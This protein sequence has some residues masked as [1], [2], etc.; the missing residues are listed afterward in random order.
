MRAAGP[1]GEQ[2]E[3][4]SAQTGQPPD[5]PQTELGGAQE[6]GQGGGP[7]AVLQQDS[8][9]GLRGAL[10]GPPQDGADSQ[11]VRQGRSATGAPPAGVQHGSGGVAGL[12]DAGLL[13][14][15]GHG[16]AGAPEGPA[17]DGSSP[18]GGQAGQ[19]AAPRGC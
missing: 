1:A 14:R 3:A 10:P 9:Q 18:D 8:G 13:Q 4:Q 6:A 17:E 15:R 2:P 11:R 19:H 12:P 16:A 5:G 7:E